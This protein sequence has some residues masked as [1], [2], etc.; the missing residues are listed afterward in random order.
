VSGG[1]KGLGGRRRGARIAGAGLALAAVAVGAG[2][3]VR[4]LSD[5]AAARAAF[6]LAEGRI[7]AEGLE[8]AVEIHRDALGIPHIEARS[9][10]DAF[11]GLGFVHAQ[12]RLAQM[13]WLVRSARGRTAEVAGAPGLAADRVARVLDLGGAAD[14]RY[15]RVDPSTRRVLE[16]YARGVNAR[17]ER[18][19]AGRVDPPLEVRRLGIPL[20]AWRP[21][22]SL[23]VLKLYAWGLSGSLDVSLVLSDLIERLGGLGA[24]PFF[25]DA[26]G[27]EVF[28]A[29]GRLPVTAGRLRE[30]GPGLARRD[31]SGS[32]FRR[33]AFG[34]VGSLRRAAGL[35]G[36]S[37]GSSAWV[38]G[39][40]HSGSGL[41][42][43]AA[44]AH[45][46]P[47]AP[48]LLHLDHIRGGEFDVAGT[49]LPGVPVVWTGRSRQVA[50]ASTH[51]RAV[52][53]DLY[54]ETLHPTDATLYHDGDEWRKL[55]QR[56]ETIEVSGGDADVLTV[57]STLHGPLVQ[58]LL[59]EE[60]EPISLAWVGSRLRDAHSIASML[61]VARASDADALVAA[62]E[63]HHEPALAVVYADSH[64]AAGMQVAG[65]I[66]HRGL[67]SG[68]VPLPGRA[69]WYDWRGRVPFERLPR[70]RL[71]SGSGW[72]V[73]AD[74]RLA[75]PGGGAQIEWLWR[76]GERAR[77]IDELLGAAVADG[78]VDVR[79]V[80]LLQSDVE[81]ARA[82]LLTAHT[83]ELVGEGEEL[84]P[85][86]LEV[87]D[88]LRRWDGRA[89]AASIGSSVYHVF[90]ESLTEELF[91]ETLGEDLMARYL[92]LPQVDP[93]YM[94][95]EIVRLAAD[96]G[97]LDSWV[98][99][100]RVRAAVR[101]SLREAWLRLSFRLGS[102][103][104]K[105]RWGRLHSLSFRPFG[106]L[107]LGADGPGEIGPFA[108]GG[109]AGTVN[110]AGYNPGAPFDVR[111]AST[112]RFAVDAGALDQV[113]V[114]LAPGQSEHP[115]HPHFRDGLRGWLAGESSLLV[116]SRLLVEEGSAARLVL[117]PGT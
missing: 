32:R 95:Y 115:R 114:S 19:R 112:C 111:V 105:W 92:A 87:A 104:K 23:A 81:A 18:V 42:L 37:I 63:N 78:P 11:F 72:T 61:A 97:E 2:L 106:A 43:L 96:G 56:V 107:R 31:S 46:E 50:W 4:L 66:P 7:Q 113:L 103:R 101:K 67:P 14:A 75:S 93:G 108:V 6:P 70:T 45:L 30:A 91:R 36:R 3:S 62:L 54:V 60:R 41:P 94:V 21:A 48:P 84:G 110:A 117:E 52:T 69:R 47:T 57:R 86:A 49:T 15:A 79:Q 1:A 65:W 38:L 24:R 8:A 25:P 35:E 10:D 68:L 28:P 51:A 83:L 99:G 116:T 27:G 55:D 12:D 98:D 20:E 71:E 76:T 16:A 22:D 13:L 29:P 90:L 39:G 74:N 9:E 44:D 85:E 59:P 100:E 80:A 64:G 40:A 77:R 17:I 82:R 88:L 89:I 33:L 73:A 34:A 109:S 26:A 53:A 5:F 102:N 58:A